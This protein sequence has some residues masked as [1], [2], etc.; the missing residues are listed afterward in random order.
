[1]STKETALTVHLVKPDGAVD[2]ALLCGI[3]DALQKQF[4]IEHSTIQIERGDTAHS[5]RLAPDE[6]V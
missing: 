6:V 5:C 1:M 4:S 2:D 3:A